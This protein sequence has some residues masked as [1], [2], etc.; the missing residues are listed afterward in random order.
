MR[1]HELR[2]TV[3]E[4]ISTIRYFSRFLMNLIFVYCVIGIKNSC[5]CEE[6]FFSE[7]LSSEYQFYLL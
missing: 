1:I 3:R 5:Q 6:I 7:F 4:E 2:D